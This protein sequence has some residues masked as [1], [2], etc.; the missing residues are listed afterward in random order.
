MRDLR[1]AS[2]V[3][4]VTRQSARRLWH[5]AILQHEHGGP[6]LSEVLWHPELPIGLWRQGNRAGALRY[7]LVSRY[8]DGSMRIFYGVTE[9]GLTGPWADLAQMAD[10]AG[11]EGPDPSE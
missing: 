6:A 2:T 5:Y 9:D 1:N 11:Y 4:N 10:S 8:P 3:H 7:D